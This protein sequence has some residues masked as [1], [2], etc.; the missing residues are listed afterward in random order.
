MA[1]F[2][3][4][5]DYGGGNIQ[6]DAANCNGDWNDVNN[7]WAW[8]DFYPEGNGAAPLGRLP[9]QLE[10]LG[11]YNE[12]TVN[13]PTSWTAQQGISIKNM[14]T[15]DYY[16]TPS[17]GKLTQGNWTTP[18]LSMY[19]NWYAPSYNP[20]VLDGSAVINLTGS[21]AMTGYVRMVGGTINGGTFGPGGG[22]VEGGVV[23]GTL[24]PNGGTVSN[25]A[26]TGRLI[27]SGGT[28]NGGTF[29]GGSSELTMTG[30]TINGGTFSGGEVKQTGGLVHGGSFTHRRWT[31]TAG[32]INGGLYAPVFPDRDS[33]IFVPP[34]GWRLNPVG[35][36][37][38][39]P[40]FAA[41]GGTYQL[42]VIPVDGVPSILL[43]QLL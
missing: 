19:G 1:I 17:Y 15:L 31:K 3:G 9:S 20:I 41:G 43:N 25:V 13:V 12:P 16:D 30:G 7:W 35:F 14:G 6:P 8:F 29:N 36:H 34:N 27:L 28:I 32:T 26:H 40:G 42:P 4:Y 18:Y 10:D 38:M 24:S 37:P 11:F 2:C 5:V 33:L 21:G 22:T 39:D 23:N